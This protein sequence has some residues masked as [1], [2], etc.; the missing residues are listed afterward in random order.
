MEGSGG[1][2]A[3]ESKEVWQGETVKRCECCEEFLYPAILISTNRSLEVWICDCGFWIEVFKDDM[4]DWNKAII[5][6]QLRD[7]ANS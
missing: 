2:G 5:A 7:A 4:K 1:T 3:S 6:E